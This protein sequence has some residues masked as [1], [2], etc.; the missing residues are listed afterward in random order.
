MVRPII[1]LIIIITIRRKSLNDVRVK[2]GADTASDHHLVVAVLKIKL[3]A[4]NNQAKRPS[5]KFNIHILH[6]RKSH[7]RRIQGRTEKQGQC[8]FLTP[9]RNS[10]KTVARSARDLEEATCMTVLGK[11]TRKQ[12]EW[13]TADTWTLIK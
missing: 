3:N 6:E 8:A 10:S 9:R 4:Y 2:H 13:I 5:H 7:N 1:K 11:K 12:K